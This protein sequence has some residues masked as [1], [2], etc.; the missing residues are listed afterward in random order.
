[1]ERDRRSQN[2][3]GSSVTEVITRDIVPGSERQ[4]EEWA[5]RLVSAAARY[6]ATDTIISPDAATP[7]RRFL[8]STSLTRS[9]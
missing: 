1:M 5:H 8:S 3:P 6:G 7:A 4:F 2:S 9:S